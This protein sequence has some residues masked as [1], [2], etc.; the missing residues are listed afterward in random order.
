[1]SSSKVKQQVRPEQKVLKVNK[2]AQAYTGRSGKNEGIISFYATADL[3]AAANLP[4]G[5]LAYDTTVSKLKIT[6]GGA[7]VLAS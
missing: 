5:I 6:S 1:M 3:P 7:W 4:N 2:L